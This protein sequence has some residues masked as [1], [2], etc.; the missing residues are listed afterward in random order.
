MAI[1]V[2]IVTLTNVALAT[3][4]MLQQQNHKHGR[5]IQFTEQCDSL[6]AWSETSAE[7]SLWKDRCFR[8]V[9]YTKFCS[10]DEVTLKTSF[11]FPALIAYHRRHRDVGTTGRRSP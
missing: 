6:T 4:L 7:D 5:L 8:A 9:L 1:V 2:T 11:A 3:V 10:A